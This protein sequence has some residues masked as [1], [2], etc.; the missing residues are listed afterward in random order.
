MLKILKNPDDSGENKT[1]APL[2]QYWHLFFK[3]LFFSRHYNAARAKIKQ[4]KTKQ[5]P[6]LKK[7]K[8]FSYFFFV[9]SNMLH[10]LLLYK[11]K[12]VEI[13]FQIKEPPLDGRRKVLFHQPN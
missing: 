4:K 2:N 5:H 7:Q 1:P 8:L 11:I 12:S 13:K 6:E 10:Q 3:V 9:L